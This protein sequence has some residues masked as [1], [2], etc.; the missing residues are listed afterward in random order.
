MRELQ[1]SD[2]VVVLSITTALFGIS[3]R[4]DQSTLGEGHLPKEQ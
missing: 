4:D 2:M 1:C 3:E